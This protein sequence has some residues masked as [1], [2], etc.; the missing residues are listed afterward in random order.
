MGGE[1][2]ALDIFKAQDSAP[3]V[4]ID[5]RGFVMDRALQHKGDLVGTLSQGNTEA[6]IF[7][8]KP[9]IRLAAFVVGLV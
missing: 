6:A 9:A 8:G 7:D 4:I 1:G 3:P 5:R 2:K